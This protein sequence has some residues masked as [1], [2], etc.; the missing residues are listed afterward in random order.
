MA[1]PPFWYAKNPENFRGLRPRTPAAP[2]AALRATSLTPLYYKLHPGYA[3]M[4]YTP[5]EFCIR[6]HVSQHWTDK[7]RG[8]PQGLSP[9]LGHQ[10]VGIGPYLFRLLIRAQKPV[11]R[12]SR[13]K[14]L[15]KIY[16]Q[17]KTISLLYN[18]NIL[19]CG[20]NLYSY[21]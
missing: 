1:L 14:C 4:Y 2:S 17:L 18:I 21:S 11:C 6:A 8:L 5:N 20:L 7:G 12:F 15:K 19:E 10:W 3:R 9:S 13:C 16:S